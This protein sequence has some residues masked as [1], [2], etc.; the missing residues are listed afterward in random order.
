[1]IVTI[2][3]I[4]S[5]VNESIVTTATTFSPS[6]LS[7]TTTFNRAA[8]AVPAAV[9]CDDADTADDDIQPANAHSYRG[10]KLKHL[11]FNVTTEK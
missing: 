2:T 11:I 5:I 6:A 3:I 7:T 9:A 10:S 8:T 1:M 4:T